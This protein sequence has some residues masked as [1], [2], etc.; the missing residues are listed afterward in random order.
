MKQIFTYK[1][2]LT[3]KTKCTYDTWFNIHYYY[4]NHEKARP[5]YMYGFEY[6]VIDNLI[7]DT[8]SII[9]AVLTFFPNSLNTLR[10]S[11]N[12][13]ENVPIPNILF[14]ATCYRT[15]G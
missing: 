8:L 14:I 9:F 10:T 12:S 7:S 6:Y 13:V 1:L 11:N 4:N 2:Y 5:K 15:F 3:G